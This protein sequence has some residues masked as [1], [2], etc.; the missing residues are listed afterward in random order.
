VSTASTTGQQHR[1]DWNALGEEAVRILQSLLRFNT[2]NVPGN[3]TPAADYL[4]GLLRGEGIE[5]E[6]IESAPGRGTVAARLR[7]EQPA[8]RPFLLT[9]H[10]DVVSVEPEKWTHD[11]F[12]GEIVDGYVWGRGALDM[13]GQVAAELAVLLA[14]ARQKVPLRRDITFVA[15]A[16]EERGGQLGAAWLWEHRRDVLDAEYAINE[17]GGRSFAAGDHRIFLAQAGEKGPSRLKITARGPAGHASTPLDDTAMAKMG[18]AL[19]RLTTWEPPA[20]VT[21]TVSVLLN[22]V[23][24]VLDDAG[25]GAVRK[26]IDDPSL[27]AIRQLPVDPHVQRLL[28]AITRDTAVPTIIEGGRSINV[29]PS[30]VTLSVDCRILPGTDPEEW[31]E[32]VQ[33]VVGE[34]V[35]VELLSR[36][37]GLEFDPESPLFAIIK[38]TMSELVPNATVAPSLT[39]GATDARHLPG[40]K[41]YGFFPYPPSDRLTTYATLVHGHDERVAVED[42][43]FA[44][45]FLYE[46]TT[47]MCGV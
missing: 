19:H 39:A 29:I 27:D 30:D 36:E 38:Q 32:L 18:H 43:H 17:G 9:G 42:I 45:R 2:V 31:R 47:R 11:P 37:R 25:A 6:V 22:T 15:F 35:E 4:A 23:A 14:L 33:S 34:E 20:R 7:A 16:D 10:T 5:A 24:G 21:T 3:E 46:V 26:L 44:A 1:V 41:T 8:A 40:I 13:K 12:G 28:R